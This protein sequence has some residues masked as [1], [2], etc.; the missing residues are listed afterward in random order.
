MAICAI[1]LSLLAIKEFMRI[2]EVGNQ[3]S[4]YGDGYSEQ[5]AI[6]GAKAYE[7]LGILSNAGL[8]DHCLFPSNSQNSCVYTHYPPGPEYLVLMSSR[9]VN[10]FDF[11]SLRIP[12]LIL[13]LMLL[14]LTIILLLKKLDHLFVVI[15][16]SILSLHPFFSRFM[17]NLHYQGHAFYLLFLQMAVTLFVKESPKKTFSS[18]FLLSF[19]QGWLSFDYFFIATLAPMVFYGFLHG[20]R[21][22]ETLLLTIFSG[23]GFAL[24]HLLHFYQV[25]LYYGS[26]EKAFEDFLNA[27][28]NRTNN[29]IIVIKWVPQ[30]A[31]NP[32]KLLSI[33][34][35]RYTKRHGFLPIS[36]DKYMLISM[37]LIVS[38]GFMK[39][40]KSVFSFCFKKDLIDLSLA[41]FVSSLW[42]IVMRQ[43]SFIHFSFIN[44][45]YFLFILVWIMWLLSRLTRLQILKTS[46]SYG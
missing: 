16:L 42:I 7:K 37:A 5:N 45:H 44:Q 28:K 39:F 20:F 46:P 26:F 32:L 22:K 1:I 13:N 6:W 18:L 36:L 3:P 31:L 12:A 29:E 15:L 33:Y 9:L 40:R 21:K 34:F 14:S 38:F 27:A 25:I 30:K 43:H 2:Q 41:F 4:K 17:H 11:N 8:P 19:F 35:S 24:A 10:S 23:A